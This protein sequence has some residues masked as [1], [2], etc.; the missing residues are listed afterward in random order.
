[1]HFFTRSV[2]TFGIVSV[3]F[4]PAFSQ[5]QPAPYFP[6]A[7]AWMEKTPAEMGLNPAKIQEAI[8][9]A[10]AGE[11]KN[12][13][14]MEQSHYQS[15]GKE[16]FGS[17]IGPF[18][19]RG[20]QTGVIIYKGYIVAKWGEPSRCDIT[21]SVTK[22]FLSSVVGLAVDKGLIRSVN[23]TVVSYVPPIELYGQP[24]QRP[25]DD[26]GKPELLNLFDTP[27]NRRIT[28]DNM[29]RQTSDW[30][31][32]LWGKPEW[33]DRP[34]KDA[35]TWL[36]RPRNAPGSVY[37]YNDVRVNALALAATSVWRKPLPQVLKEN[38][39]DPIGASNTWRWTGYR[40]AW[41]VLDGQPV[42]SVSGG[43]H[44]GGGMFINA[45]DMARFGLLTLHRGNWNGKQ[46]LSEQWVK[47]AT[48]PTPAQPTY[49]YMN[50]FLNTDKKPLPSAPAN[51]YYHVGNGANIVYVDPDHE[52]VMVVRW[53]ENY[54]SSLDGIVKRLLEAFT[55]TVP[56]TEI[57]LTD[58]KVNAGTI[59]IG[60]PSNITK[61]SGYD[62]QPSFTQD[63]KKLLYTQQANGQTD[64]WAYDLGKKINTT[65][66]KTTESEYSAT[67]MPDG[68]HFSVIRVEP[69]GTQMLWQFDLAT[70]QNPKLVL[71]SIKPVGY[72]CWFGSDS[73][74]LFVLGQPNM[75][76][77]ARVSTD[78]SQTITT[79]VGR[80]L[81]RIPSQKTVSFVHK[82]SAAEWQVESLDMNTLQTKKLIQTPAGSEDC[83]W[84]VDGTL[85]MAQGAKLYKWNPKSD[86]DWQL[87]ADWSSMGIKQITRLAVNPKGTQL[88][89]V[90]Q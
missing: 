62:N 48:T 4:L 60:K 28:W 42:Q 9:F 5:K 15:F 76:Q 36:T 37:E 71:P 65:L 45:F 83:A 14:S 52:L 40:N 13:R 89:F 22:S 56:D 17:A 54:S 26:F 34:D 18:A 11:S 44:W 74:V 61:R 85:L 75:L 59:S 19:D 69:D 64:I 87:L 68:K 21:H 58:L 7:H 47:Q 72:H 35:A 66:T 29:L 73:L 6:P 80:S 63:G 2:F 70:G 78:Q 10:K 79:N 57:Y 86:T 12:P 16:P 25:A 55:P 88:A 53:I 33:A 41:I 81:L 32:T 43:G 8:A 67:V 77:L 31:G 39:M 38:I 3:A 24:V 50:W 30:E 46:L 84:T 49:G 27:H 23:D 90:G 20:D 82:L 1:M 51:V